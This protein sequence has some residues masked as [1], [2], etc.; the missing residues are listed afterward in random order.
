[1]PKAGKKCW[2][3]AS[4][5]RR[6]LANPLPCGVFAQEYHVW[7]LRESSLQVTQMWP[8]W[9]PYVL[10]AVMVGIVRVK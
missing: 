8:R 3:V 5:D 2:V 4:Q 10:D 6:P 1:M 9:D 7:Q